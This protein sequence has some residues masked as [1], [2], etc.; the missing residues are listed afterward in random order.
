MDIRIERVAQVLV[1]Y[2]AGVKPGDW[3]MLRGDPIGE[4][5]LRAVY[6]CILEAGGHPQLFL[7]PA[8][9]AYNLLK[10]GNDDQLAFVSPATR[11]VHEQVDVRISIWGEVNTKALSNIDPSREQKLNK[12]AAGLFQTFM[13]RSASGSLRWVG[14]LYPTNAFAQDAEM[15][16]EEY[17][18]FVYGAA[19]VDDP[20][21]IARWKEVSQ[22]QQRLVDWLA[23]HDQ[24]H[25]RGADADLRLSIKGRTFVNADGKSNFPDGEIFTGPVESSANGWVRFTYPAVLSNREVT[26]IEFTFED[27]KVVKATATKNDDALQGLLDTDAGSRFLGELGI[28]T[29]PGITRFTK[30]ALFDEKIQGTF[31]LAVGASYP[32]TGGRNQS[33]VHEDI[34][35]DLRDGEIVVDGEVFYRNGDFV[36]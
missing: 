19:L 9:E 3:V 4:P 12:A 23:G 7:T 25:I 5:M 17:E 33:S 32:E 18:D 16:L 8:W 28:G 11:L 10:Y 30:N 35:C 1:N 21:P 15:S 14:A 31:H 24:V 27:G 6:R 20:D 29:N 34:V 26:G 22:R 2:S 13:E 36:I